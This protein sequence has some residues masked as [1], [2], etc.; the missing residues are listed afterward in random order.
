MDLRFGIQSPGS[1]SQDLQSKVPDPA[2]ESQGSDSWFQIQIPAPG[3]QLTDPESQF[4]VPD[5]KI[6]DSRAH[7]QDSMSQVPGAKS[8]I[9]FDNLRA[10]GIHAT[11]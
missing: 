10:P 1:Q 7:F 6:L 2:P 9:L 5:S 11:Y 8:L 4:S 3:S